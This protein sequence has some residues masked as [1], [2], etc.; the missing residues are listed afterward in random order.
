MRR[1]LMV[2]VIVSS[3]IAPSLS[4]W[5]TGPPT[6]ITFPAG[7][8]DL[9]NVNE[10]P[11]GAVCPFPAHVVLHALGPGHLIVFD[12]QGVGFAGMTLGALKVDV[13]N[14]NTGATVTVNISGPGGLNGDGLPVL[15]RGPWVL[16]EPIDQ[17]GIRFFH[18]VTSFVP[19]SYGVHAIPIAGREEDLCDRVG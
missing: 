18:G 7:D 13:T 3:I 5:A 11:A 12:G 1:T 14:M 19:A 2:A 16:F 10:G 4:A 8:T 15:G 6:I 9:G 17:G